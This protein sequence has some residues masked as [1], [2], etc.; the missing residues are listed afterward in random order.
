MQKNNHELYP[1]RTYKNSAKNGTIKLSAQYLQRLKEQ[2]QE[3]ALIDKNTKPKGDSF[4]KVL[5]STR[6]NSK[7]ATIVVT[8]QKDTTEEAY[9]LAKQLQTEMAAEL[10]AYNRFAD[11]YDG[12]MEWFGEKEE[13]LLDNGFH[14]RIRKDYNS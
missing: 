12:F 5:F 8:K 7:G 3:M 9:V 13:I 11:D 2:E 10:V 6:W 1:D 14:K 4:I